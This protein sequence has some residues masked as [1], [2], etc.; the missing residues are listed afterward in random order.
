M[1]GLPGVF[2]LTAVLESRKAEE[3]KKLSQRKALLRCTDEFR[4][5]LSANKDALLH[6][7]SVSRMTCYSDAFS[8]SVN[9]PK[10]K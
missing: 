1:A 10:E 4:V 8:L 5:C 7:C 6:D 3:K 2:L 9:I